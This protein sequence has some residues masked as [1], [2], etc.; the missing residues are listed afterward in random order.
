MATNQGLEPSEDIQETLK[1]TAE[2]IESQIGSKKTSI[3]ESMAVSKKLQ[4]LRNR[5]KST[6]GRLAKA[7]NQ[8][9][10]LLV[11][12]TD[13]SFE[14][15]NAIRRC[16]TRVRSEFDILEKIIGA[17]KEIYAVDGAE[18]EANVDIDT[19]IQTLDNE[20]CD[21]GMQVDLS[22]ETATMHLKERLEMGEAESESPSLKSAYIDDKSSKASAS[23]SV[24]EKRRVEAR[25]A[26]ERLLQMQQEQKRQE[27]E[28]RKRAA[29]LELAK[30]RTEEARKIAALNQARAN[31]A[32]KDTGFDAI[33]REFEKRDPSPHLMGNWRRP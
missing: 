19:I 31:A 24:V 7:R 2:D 30:Q 22:I 17:F 15:K 6:K 26:N 29:E 23:S 13:G 10:D 5:K 27:D 14:S 25:Q 9:K 12:R 16:I 21:I 1:T 20:L 4:N 3:V 11:A 18:H 32:Q 28:F 33:R 8:L